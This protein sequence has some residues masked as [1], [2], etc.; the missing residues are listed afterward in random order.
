MAH[1]ASSR[2][3]RPGVP[4]GGGAPKAAP[5]RGRGPGLNR[6]PGQSTAGPVRRRVTK[7]LASQTAVCLVTF[8]AYKMAIVSRA[9]S[10]PP[11]PSWRPDSVARP[12][13]C[14]CLS[15]VTAAVALAMSVLPGPA[16]DH[17]HPCGQEDRSSRPGVPGDQAHGRPG[18]KRHRQ[19]PDP[20]REVEDGP[21]AHASTIRDRN[22]GTCDVSTVAADWWRSLCDEWTVRPA[23]TNKAPIM[24][25]T[26][27]K[28]NS[29]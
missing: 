7:S 15:A 18:C 24:A 13:C 11:E 26:S 28:N 3:S 4:P 19:V 12:T 27:T 20:V 14:W 17:P 2:Y 25:V 23:A 8:L 9:V 16:D 21:P 22:A 5:L 6:R 29:K 1:A 10:V